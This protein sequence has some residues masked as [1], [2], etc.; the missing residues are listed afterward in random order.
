MMYAAP[1][2]TNKM[3][4][5][6]HRRRILI[7]L[8]RAILISPTIATVSND[9]LHVLS[10]TLTVQLILKFNNFKYHLRAAFRELPGTSIE[11]AFR[12]PLQGLPPETNVDATLTG[13]LHRM[14]LE[15]NKVRAILNSGGRQAPTVNRYVS[16]LMDEWQLLWDNSDRGGNTYNYFSSIR[17]VVETFSPFVWRMYKFKKH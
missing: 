17:T 14:G 13:E 12:H 9:A 8:Q 5:N 4:T 3:V 15:P 2:S 11:S 16:T 10:G 1:F 7:T 6:C